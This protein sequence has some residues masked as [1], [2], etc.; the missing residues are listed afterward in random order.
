M[1]S[2]EARTLRISS[3]VMPLIVRFTV[4]NNASFSLGESIGNT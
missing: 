2:H 4:L 3:R 1:N